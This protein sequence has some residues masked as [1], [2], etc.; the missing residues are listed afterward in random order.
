MNN[1]LTLICDLIDI[2]VLFDIIDFNPICLKQLFHI[3]EQQF[4]ATKCTYLLLLRS[5]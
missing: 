3:D 4:V 1:N 2:R 5:I